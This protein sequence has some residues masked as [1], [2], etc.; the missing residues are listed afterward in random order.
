MREQLR[1][2]IE[3]AL[4]AL[5]FPARESPGKR[6]ARTLLAPLAHLAARIAVRRRS[7]IRHLPAHDRPA[8]VVIG[9]LVVGGTGK[10]PATIAT[11]LALAARG[12]KVGLLSGG[13]RAARQAPRLVGPDADPAADGD[14]PV[15][16]A[17]ET[18]LPVAAGRRRAEALALLLRARPELDVVVSDDGL[19][20][21]ALPRS[22]EVAV[23]DRR[24]AGN[25]RLLPAGPLREPLSGAGRLDALLLNDTDR[26][27]VDGPPAFVFRVEPV[28]FRALAGDRR[29]AADALVSRVAGSRVAAVAGIGSP[30]RFFATLRDLGLRFSE[31]PLPDHASIDPTTLAAIDADWI[32]MT[33]KDA[34]KCRAF[35]DERCWALETRARIPPAFIA[36]LEERLRGRPIA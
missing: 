30:Q 23:F 1:G 34:V 25:G 10:T 6:I 11:A 4:Q 14:E 20:H 15:L 3:R 16:L 29:L 33:T 2:R 32:L 24:G 28:T 31:H 27:P 19:Q 5:W 36:W 22:V 8:V 12:W 18:G 7:R 9:N 21:A 26:A 17:T 35:A 13:Y